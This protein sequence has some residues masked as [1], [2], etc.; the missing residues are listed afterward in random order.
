MQ[1]MRENEE[2]FTVGDLGLL[3]FGLLAVWLLLF[4]SNIFR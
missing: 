2:K 3:A 1:K 4:Q